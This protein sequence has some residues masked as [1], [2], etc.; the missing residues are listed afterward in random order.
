MDLVLAYTDYSGI[1]TLTHLLYVSGDL[2]PNQWTL[3]GTSPDN[4][5]VKALDTYET[6]TL[7]ANPASLPQTGSLGTVAVATPNGITDSAY[8]D[9]DYTGVNDCRYLHNDP[10][11]PTSDTNR[12][13]VLPMDDSRPR[14]LRCITTM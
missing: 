12:Q 5:N 13:A 7:R 9:F 6:A 1:K 3:K 4:F 11:P 10:T 8:V 14:R 2:G